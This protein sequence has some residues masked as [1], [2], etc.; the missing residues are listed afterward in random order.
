MLGAPRVRLP[1]PEEAG[2]AAVPPQVRVRYPQPGMSQEGRSGPGRDH[3]WRTRTTAPRDVPRG[4]SRGPTAAHS[5][6]HPPRHRHHSLVEMERGAPSCRRAA[7][8]WAKPRSHPAATLSVPVCDARCGSPDRTALV[9]AGDQHS[10]DT[11]QRV[12]VGKRTRPSARRAKEVRTR[13][14]GRTPDVDHRPMAWGEHRTL[15]HGDARDVGTRSGDEPV[16]AR[17][18]PGLSRRIVTV[19]NCRARR[20]RVHPRSHVPSE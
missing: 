4:T 10:H 5:P 18:Y 9:D 14:P 20:R 3:R 13:R 2:G 17:A 15:S 11:A 1:S 19:L 16:V 7:A 6:R 8:L 12:A